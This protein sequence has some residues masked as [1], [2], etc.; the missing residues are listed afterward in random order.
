MTT[1]TRSGPVAAPRARRIADWRHSPAALLFLLPCIAIFG[2]FL[3]Y[4]LVRNVYVG[5]F[6][7]NG[8]SNVTDFIGLDNF[9][10]V[11]RARRC[12]APPGTRWCSAWSP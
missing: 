10:W 11:S 7:W 3:A 1:T 4:P 6:D 12:S 2:V 5:L 8:L 9:V